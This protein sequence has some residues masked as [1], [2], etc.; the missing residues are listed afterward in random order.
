MPRP[1]NT[2]E[3]RDQILDGL[4]RAMARKGYEGATIADVAS[5]AH[6][7]PGL[8][9]YHFE[10]KLEIL[11]QLL[12]R[13]VARHDA[14]L[15]RALEAAAPHPSAQLA[16]FL[17]FHLSLGPTADP[18]ALACWVT[19]SGE[20]IRQNSVRKEF[21]AALASLRDRLAEIIRRGV[22]QAEFTCEDADAAAAALL[23][24]IQ[25]Y[26]VL[27]ATARG[28]IPRGSAAA[29]A[30]SMAEGLVRPRRPLTGGAS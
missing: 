24:A 18:D 2:E 27:A 8:V 4:L 13:L 9:H 3:R 16:A 12:R 15:A 25:G 5:G 11:I 19:L 26:F 20:A 22:A 6:L 14:A 10:N 21:D 17:E 29:S 1:S 30:R 7:T 28:L 23:A